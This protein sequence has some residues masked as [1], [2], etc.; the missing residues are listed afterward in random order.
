MSHDATKAALG[1]TYSS[2]KV[3]SDYAGDP[4]TYIAGLAVRRKSDNTLSVAAADGQWLGV[5]LGRSLSDH[6]KTSVVRSGLRVPILLEAKPAYGEIEITSYANLVS[7]TD[8]AIAVGATSFVAQAGAAT[9]GDATFQAAS[10]NEAT[11]TSLA[12]QINAHAT[13]G[14]LVEARANGAV[15]EL[16]AK[17]NTTAGNS[18]ILTYTDNDSNV[19]ATVTGEGTLE[20]GGDA[21]DYVAVG[22]KVYISDTTGKADDPY[23]DSTISDA[24]YVSGVLTGIDESGAEVACA[25]I[26]MPGGL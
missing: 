17:L 2:D 19:G 16:R 3:V 7:G 13:A 1:S 10:S 12:T 21:A 20:D 23:S 14:A 11:A 9:P 24:V 5:S 25:L 6:K 4:A 8:D 15:V 22:Q 26:D 18:I